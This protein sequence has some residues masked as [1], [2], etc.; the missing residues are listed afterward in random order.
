MIAGLAGG[1]GAFGAISLRYLYPTNTN[2]RLWQ[3]VIE[4]D[5]VKVGES[6]RYQGPSGETVNIARQARNGDADDFI[7]LSSTCPHLGCQVRWEPQNNRFHCPC[8]NGVFDPSG[9][10]TSGPPAE[11]GQSLS[12]YPL[13]VTDGLLRISVPPPQFADSEAKGEILAAGEQVSGPGHDPCLS[14]SPAR[15]RRQTGNLEV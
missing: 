11:A 4:T 12:R 13:Q 7:A 3:F 5:R 10:A 15:P 8:H 2:N 6:I 1:Y 14:K 9:V